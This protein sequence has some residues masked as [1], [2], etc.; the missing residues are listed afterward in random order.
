MLAYPDSLQF[1]FFKGSYWTIDNNYSDASSNNQLKPK[2]IETII[3]ANSNSS[4]CDSPQTSLTYSPSQSPGTTTSQS[5]A[6][7]KPATT[8]DNTSRQN[9]KEPESFV[10]S[11]PIFDDLNASFKRLY[12]SMLNNRDLIE[13]EFNLKMSTDCF[14]KKETNN[15]NHSFQ[16]PQS[17]TFNGNCYIFLY[18]LDNFECIT[19]SH[20]AHFERYKLQRFQ[21]EFRLLYAKFQVG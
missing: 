3:E 14:M 12:K 19:I 4:T 17:D 7:K 5:E 8:N 18:E 13:P 9:A 10:D 15:T 1:K 16:Q 2:K 21:H 11:S 6:N 20:R